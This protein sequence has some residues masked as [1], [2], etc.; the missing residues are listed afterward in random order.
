M[1]LLFSRLLL[2]E[3]SNST[4]YQHPFSYYK[5]K[6]NKSVLKFVQKSCL[7]SG[8][9]MLFSPFHSFNIVK[10]CRNYSSVSHV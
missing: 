4:L 8:K 7:F 5:T 6:L 10:K 9:S 2:L 1:L 3:V